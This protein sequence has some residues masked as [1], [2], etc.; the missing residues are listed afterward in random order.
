MPYY[1]VV[2]L[3]P[4][5]PCLGV[6]QSSVGVLLEV[7]LASLSASIRGAGPRVSTV[8]GSLRRRDCRAL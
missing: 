4:R 3:P 8:G 2:V 1:I 7:V 6:H 5:L